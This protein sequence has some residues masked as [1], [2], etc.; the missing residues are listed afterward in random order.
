V[1]SLLASTTPDIIDRITISRPVPG[2]KIAREFIRQ[3]TTITLA[4]VWTSGVKSL[5]P[6][7]V[8]KLISSCGLLNDK[9]VHS[10]VL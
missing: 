5:L 6:P 7:T 3:Q 1:K 9:V 10:P 8:L 2:L 4:L